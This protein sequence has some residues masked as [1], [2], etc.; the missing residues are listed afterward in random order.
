MELCKCNRESR[1]IYY[2]KEEGCPN[3]ETNPTY[4]LKC[5]K[6]KKL[7]I[8]MTCDVAEEVDE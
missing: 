2:C 3:K 6:D 1:A 7:H 8:H 4:C 5:Y